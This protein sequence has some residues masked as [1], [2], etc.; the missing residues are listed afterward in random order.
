MGYTSLHYKPTNN[1]YEISFRI[2][3]DEASIA[4]QSVT[5]VADIVITNETPK[6]AH[7]KIFGKDGSVLDEYDA[8][9]IT[10]SDIVKD[11]AA[12][13]ADMR[14][15]DVILEY[16]MWNFFA[17]EDTDVMVPLMQEAEWYYRDRNKEITTY[18]PN[19][20]KIRTYNFAAG[21]KK[22]GISTKRSIGTEQ[23]DYMNMKTAYESWVSER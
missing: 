16:G 4:A 23:K 7:Y 15:G 8:K 11:S 6:A 14:N 22:I 12:Q 18:R 17:F 13:K 5:G 9:F 10:I 20:G 21:E 1:G 2:D 19:D 3:D